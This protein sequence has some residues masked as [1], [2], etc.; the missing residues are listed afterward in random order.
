M[1]EKKNYNNNNISKNLRNCQ[2]TKAL[3]SPCILCKFWILKPASHKIVIIFNTWDKFFSLSKLRVNVFV[4]RSEIEAP[5][6]ITQL[7]H[8]QDSPVRYDYWPS[9]RS[10][11]GWILIETQ[12]RSITTLTHAKKNKKKT[13]S[14]FSHFD[15]ARLINKGIFT[16][17]N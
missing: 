2:K 16:W 5:M 10:R 6:L 3:M 12:S 13:R 17:D 7:L 4:A 14:I 1:K 15:R 9:V 11:Y 8:K